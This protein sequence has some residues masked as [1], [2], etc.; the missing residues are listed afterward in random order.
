MCLVEPGQTA[1]RLKLYFPEWRE[2]TS[3]PQILKTLK[4]FN[5]D[6][7]DCPPVQMLP[8]KEIAF[9]SEESQII[10]SEL[11]KLLTK[12]VIVKSQH[13]HGEFLS[14]IFLRKKKTGGYRLILNLKNLN[15]YISNHH[16][17][18]ESLTSAILPMTPGCYM[19]SV[20][21]Q[22]AYYSVPIN[23]KCQKYLK[24]SWQ[25]ELFQFTCLPNGLASA[26]RLFT[27]LLKPVYSTLR[28]MGHTNV[29]Y[30]DDSYLQGPSFNDCSNNVQDTVH[31]FTKVG[32]LLN[33]EKS[34]LVPSHE[35]TF[36]GFILNSLT[37]TVRPTPE[38]AEK[39]KQKCLAVL[40][41][42][43]VSI[44]DVSEVIGL[45]VSMF[46]GVEYAQL[47]YRSLEID[48][49]KALKES[50]GNYNS[51][52]TL[53]VTSVIDL[54][55]WIKN[56]ESSF[57]WI[58]HGDPLLSLY[59]D[60]SKEGW[61]AVCKGDKAG[62]RWTVT[63][64]NCHINELETL[65]A[66]F[67]LKSFCHS[68][69]NC[70]INIYIDNTTAVSYIN[71]MGG[72]HSLECNKITPEIWTWCIQRNIWVTAISLPGK[73]NVDADRESRTF[74]DNTE[75]SLSENIF[76]SIVET[77]GMPSI[78]LFASRINRKVSRYVSWRPDPEAQ[79]VDA[80]S[81][82]WS[83]EQFYAFPPFSLILRCLK[84]IEME[85]G[86]GII[87]VPVWP[88][89][90]W[91]PKLMS[92]LVDKP[93]LLPVTRGTLYLPSKPSQ[94]HPME[95]KLKLIA[96]KLSGNPLRSKAFLQKLPRLSSSRGGKAHLNSTNPT[97][98]NGLT[99]VIENRLVQFVP[100]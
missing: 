3:D 71:A 63:E 7:V 73:E 80:F 18:M 17:K 27:K 34:I 100:L 83:Q 30:I 51:V 35:L 8:P 87:I 54:K 99:S 20:D 75:W 67:A 24:F 70:H 47:F 11:D 16:F 68:M 45:M 19:A 23:E 38:K 31:L 22:D 76:H 92:L 72:T 10:S 32:F 88:T 65:A 55:W 26:P 52:M 90:P 96:C 81:C 4:G 86:E 9:N 6:F 36:L 46:P 49:I 44:H 50:R 69:T 66:F 14:T 58:S 39:L 85:E 62:G 40:P 78:D 13:C 82:S 1:G 28:Q 29:G 64:S 94:P 33:Q 25:G 21:L 43:H 48:K 12:G 74:N 59:S 77:Y 42:T 98:K 5:V 41:K 61:G 2:L 56:V 60:A 91:Y 15:Q 53:S 93:R 95:G 84:K 89:Q 37:M 57:K 97:T 79:F